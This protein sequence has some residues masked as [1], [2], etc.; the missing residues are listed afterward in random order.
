MEAIEK[1]IERSIDLERAIYFNW[2]IRAMYFDSTHHIQDIHLRLMNSINSKLLT[3][4]YKGWR[5]S[6]VSAS[7]NILGDRVA[8]NK[9]IMQRY[10]KL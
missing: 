10:A 3:H 1:Q 9:Q 5:E 4:Y 8:Y 6:P 7:M 2:S